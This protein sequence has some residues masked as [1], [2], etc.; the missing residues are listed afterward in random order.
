LG[1]HPK[2]RQPSRIVGHKPDDD[3][4][5]SDFIDKHPTEHNDNH[6]SNRNSNWRHGE[7]YFHFNSAQASI[8]IPFTD[9]HH[10]L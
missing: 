10:S 2:R 1:H 4:D 5:Y 7:F 8:D 9:F 3:S 6:N